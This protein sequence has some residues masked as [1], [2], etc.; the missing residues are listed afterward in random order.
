M[1]A[2]LMLAAALGGTPARPPLD[3]HVVSVSW[4]KQHLKDRDL[5]ILQVVRRADSMMPHIPGSQLVDGSTFERDDMGSGATMDMSRLPSAEELHAKMSRFGISNGSHVVA[6]FTGNQ[7]PSATRMMLLL[8]YG[9]I[10]RVSLLDGGF[11]AWKR[12]GSAVATDRLVPPPG[13]VTAPLHT[14]VAV[15]YAYVQQHLRAPHFRII[16]AR[17]PVYYT[18]TTEM[19]GKMAM[20]AGHI[21]GAKNV[22]FT[23]LSND[24][25]LLISPEQIRAKFRAAGVEPGDTVIAYCHVGM[26]ATAVV[27]GAQLIG[28]PVRLYVGSFHDWADHKLPIEFSKP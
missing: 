5:V 21:P 10:E 1:S 26:Q 6:V 22:P 7:L 2:L 4:L 19:A 9:G 25:G 13:R 14:Q 16:D 15:D 28:Q 12:A 8:E 11:E 24:D 27:L 23:S 17:D 18:S 20:A 3:D